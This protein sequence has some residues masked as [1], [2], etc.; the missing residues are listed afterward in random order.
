MASC[1]VRAGS[2]LAGYQSVPSRLLSEIPRI[3]IT[4]CN[5][6]GTVV[7]GFS[8]QTLHWNINKALH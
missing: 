1:K 5:G 3:L 2:G 7:G 8:T 6:V 4:P